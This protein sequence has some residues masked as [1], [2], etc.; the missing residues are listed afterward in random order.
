MGG[1]GRVT[2]LASHRNVSAPAL[3][4][5]DE[6]FVEPELSIA[7]EQAESYVDFC[8]DTCRARGVDLFVP[9]RARDAVADRSET[10]AALGVKLSLAGDGHTLRLLDDKARFHPQAVAL[11]LPM[12]R[13]TRINDASS[14]VAAFDALRHDGLPACIKP[15]SGVFG[16]GFWRLVEGRSLFDQLMALDD[17][18]LSPAVAIQALQEAPGPLLVCEYL[19]GPEWSVDLVA[20]LGEVRLA[21][22]RRKGVGGQMLEVKGPALE[23]ARRVVAAFSLSGLVNVQVRAAD[24]EGADLRLLEINPRMSGGCLYTVFSGANLPWW[25]VALAL[26]LEKPASAPAPMGGALVSPVADAVAQR[27]GEAR[28]FSR[29]LVDSGFGWS[30]R[31]M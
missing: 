20:E 1:Q 6:A 14:F 25:H 23:L 27:D 29:I 24:P 31:A 21:V 18:R 4:A 26:G 15:P 9:Q 11:G 5:A 7:P 16:A 3:L 28:L 30:G 12:P 8:L 2:T 19:A 22:G 17:R 13:T 10:F